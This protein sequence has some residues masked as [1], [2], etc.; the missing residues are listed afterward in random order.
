[1][2]NAMIFLKKEFQTLMLNLNDQIEDYI[3]YN[4]EQKNLLKRRKI[5]D[6]M[7]KINFLRDFL[8]INPLSHMCI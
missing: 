3:I 8:A 5:Q 2:K 7:G 4:Y 1:M 6:Y